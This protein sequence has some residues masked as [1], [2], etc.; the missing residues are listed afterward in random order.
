MS[1][2]D[3]DPRPSEKPKRPYVAPRLSELGSV[4]ELTKGVTGFANPEVL[5]NVSPP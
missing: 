2:K 5:P 3:Q 1:S 4:T